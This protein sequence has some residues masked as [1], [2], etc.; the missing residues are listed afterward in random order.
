MRKIKETLIGTFHLLIFLMGGTIRLDC[1]KYPRLL[2]MIPKLLLVYT[3]IKIM[4]QIT[5]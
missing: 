1:I 2:M 3:I 5:K 4:I